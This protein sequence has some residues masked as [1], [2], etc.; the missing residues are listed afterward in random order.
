MVA[1]VVQGALF[2]S[3]FWRDL[4]SASRRSSC[5]GRRRDRQLRHGSTI[6]ASKS[7]IGWYLGYTAPSSGY[8][9]AGALIV[10][11]LRPPTLRKYYSQIFALGAEITKAIVIEKLSFPHHW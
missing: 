5:R 9:A 6:Y 2:A 7:P 10:L 3:L 11:M 8:G 1:E 4:Q